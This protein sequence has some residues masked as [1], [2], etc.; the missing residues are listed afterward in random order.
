[1]WGEWAEANEIFTYMIKLIRRKYFL[2]AINEKY[3]SLGRNEADGE[4]DDASLH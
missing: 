4:H 1:M 2:L 3:H